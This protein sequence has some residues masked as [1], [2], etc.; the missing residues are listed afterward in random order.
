MVVVCF[1]LPDGKMTVRQMFIDQFKLFVVLK[2]S[3][4]IREQNLV[5]TD[6]YR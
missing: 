2:P 6:D 3:L 5:S 4:Q 1:L